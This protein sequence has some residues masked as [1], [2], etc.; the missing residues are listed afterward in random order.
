[1]ALSNREISI[2]RATITCRPLR[3]EQECSIAR[4]LSTHRSLSFLVLLCGRYVI[5]ERGAKGKVQV[6]SGKMVYSAVFLADLGALLDLRKLY[7]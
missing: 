2:R 5:K 6:R 7:Y 3:T 1:M 4:G